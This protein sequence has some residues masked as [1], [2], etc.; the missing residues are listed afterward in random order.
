MLENEIFLTCIFPRFCPSTEKYGLEK[1]RILAHFT[2]WRAL[3][4]VNQKHVSRSLGCFDQQRS[5]VKD[6]I[7]YI[8]KFYVQLFFFLPVLWWSNCTFYI[9]TFYINILLYIF[10]SHIYISIC[11]LIHIDIYVIL[12]TWYHCS[13]VSWPQKISFLKNLIYFLFIIFLH[14]SIFTIYWI[15]F[16]I[17]VL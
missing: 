9:Y 10:Y 2:Q 13:Q 5:G 12:R 8:F 7:K 17:F 4:R 3:T 1:S 11:M 6:H 15:S 14:L 16:F